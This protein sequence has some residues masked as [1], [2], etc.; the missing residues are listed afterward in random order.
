VVVAAVDV[1]AAAQVLGREQLGERLRVRRRIQLA[2]QRTVTRRDARLRLDPVARALVGEEPGRDLPDHLVLPERAQETGVRDLADDR[3][4]QL[5]AVAERLHGLEHLRPD[6]RD[7]PLLALADHHLPGLHPLLA[8]R[9]AVEVQVDPALARHLGEGG[10]EAGGAAVLER[11]DEARLDELD[12]DLD[13]LLAH[14]RVAHLD[15]R[16]LVGVVLAELL[17]REHGRAADPVA[18]GGGAVEDDEVPRPGRA[19]ARDP[20]G[21]E[22]ADAHRVHE[23]VVRVGAV[24]DG[25]AADRGHPDRVAVGADPGDGPVEPRVARREAKPVEQGDRPGAHRD[26]VPQDPAD[27]RR[28]SLERLHRRGVVVALDLEADGLAVA[29]VEHA[30]VL[31]GALQH[32]FPLGGKPLQQES[33]VLVAAVLRPEEREDRQLEMVRLA[34][35]QRD[36]ALQL[37]VGQSECAMERDFGDLGQVIHRSREARRRPSRLEAI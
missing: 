6:D 37:S 31:T 36:D 9:H 11:L 4:V 17:A 8:Q 3:V 24:E 25:L 15:G 29:E 12:R 21:G 1:P 26:D 7:H 19:R 14:E 10:G 18:A 16:P 27:A 34:P 32:A 5:P 23:H 13:Q 22:E 33:R 2:L 28:G 35:E 20:V 30:R